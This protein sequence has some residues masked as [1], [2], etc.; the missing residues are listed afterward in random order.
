[1]TDTTEIAVSIVG[2]IVCFVAYL[3]FGSWQCSSQWSRSGL[4]T[5]WG[6]IQG[7]VVELPDGRWIP[8]DRVREIE[9]APK[10]KP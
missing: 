3:I 4:A 6:P 10:A 7:C 8:A 5:S 1:M 2:L 9:I